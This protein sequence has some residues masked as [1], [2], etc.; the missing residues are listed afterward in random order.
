MF[1]D[2]IGIGAQKAGT[3]WLDRNLRAHPQIWMPERKELHYFDRRIADM[4]SPTD[5]WSASIFETGR[6][7]VTG[8]I[9]PG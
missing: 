5:E 2:F 1:P 9:T 7:R 6:A 3:T 4:R 8:E